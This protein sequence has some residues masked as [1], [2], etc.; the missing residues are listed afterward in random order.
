MRIATILSPFCLLAALPFSS[1][2]ADRCEHSAPR[3]LDLDLAGVKT[4]I[5]EIGPHELSVTGGKTTTGAVRGKACASDAKQLAGLVVTQS[6]DADKLLVRAERNDPARAM[7]WSGAKYAYL[8]LD[9]S[10]PATI[11]V[12][13]K[14]G[15]GDAT[16]DGVASLA[17]DVGS[18]DLEARRIRGT[19]YADVGSGDID[20]AD[21]G[22]LHV[23]SVGSGDLNA[24]DV[25]GD[26]IAGSVNSGDLRI[27]SA[28]GRVRIDSIGSGDAELSGVAGDV[29][30]D[31]IGSGNLTAVDVRGNLIVS[32]VGS[33]SVDHRN[34]A[35]QV[36]IPADD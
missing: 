7:S 33:G 25:R 4:V 11:A 12:R 2:A 5:F 1:H 28:G 16:V 23:V 26:A 24:R 32:S 22:A 35:G 34:V 17:A 15:S 13:V 9:A 20:A 10:I 3:E 18:G 27:D 36:R 30:V 21:I 19:M 8:T 14:V 29:S 31:S 6:R